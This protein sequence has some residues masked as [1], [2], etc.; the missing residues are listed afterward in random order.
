VWLRELVA[1]A[2][3]SDGRRVDAADE[4][5]I[6]LVAPIARRHGSPR[7]VVEAVWSVERR[8]FGARVDAPVPPEQIRR[9]VFELAAERS[10]EEALAL[11]AHELG[12]EE[13]SIP[14]LL[15]ADRTGARRLVSRASPRTEAELASAYNLALVQALLGRATEVVALVRASVRGVVR[16]A[17][18]LGLM[19][20]VDE[21][22]DGTTR[23]VLSGPM[24]LFRDT[25]KYGR[26]LAR[27]FPA[28]VATPGWSVE[29]RVLLDGESLRLA[30]DGN[31][32]L[33]RTHAIQ[34]AHDSRLEAR[35]ERDLRRLGSSWRVERE[36]AVVRVAARVLH[37]DFT[38]V[39]DRGRVLVEIAGYWTPEYLAQKA[40]LLDAV[41]VPFVM[42]ADARH[43]PER[44]ALDPR[45][46]LFRGAI[47]AASVLTACERALDRSG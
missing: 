11:A 3:A 14:S 47:D 38:L 13:T 17:K 25:L 7:R 20:V 46:L 18:L 8:R 4:R 33:P 12:L 21:I 36:S 42:C 23:L 16:A 31:S 40:A 19:M 29:A 37:P 45:V 15:F 41:R 30:L 2:G 27:W 9:L 35:F 28:V 43:A 22:A 5:V 6:S 24:A 10:R 32:P 39:S 44:L 1:E 34:R 26:A